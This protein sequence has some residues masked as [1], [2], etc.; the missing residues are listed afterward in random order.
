MAIVRMADEVDTRGLTEVG[1]RRDRH[2]DSYTHVVE[3]QGRLAYHAINHQRIA[4]YRSPA[5]E[6]RSGA[7]SAIFNHALTSS[8]HQHRSRLIVSGVGPTEITRSN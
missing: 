4:I 3:V 8:V 6:L 5:C 7:A 2:E 1:C